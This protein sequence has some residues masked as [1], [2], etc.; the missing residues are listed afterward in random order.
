MRQHLTLLT[1]ASVAA[2]AVLATLPAIA[3]NTDVIEKRQQLMKNNGR[4]A[5][6]ASQMLKGEVAFDPAKGME[7]FR[8]I[9]ADNQEFRTLFP[10]DSKTGNDTEASP[11]IWEKKDA[12][13]Q[14][15]DKI[16]AD[17]AAAI[18]ANPQTLDEFKVAFGKV[19]ANCK[20]CHEQFR[21]DK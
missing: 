17:A 7:I 14:A 13:A 8:T 1:A 18:A 21:V 20:G 2:A 19:A 12:F 3:Q 15:N 10:D 11:A 6:A 16:E 5:K 4:S 9:Q